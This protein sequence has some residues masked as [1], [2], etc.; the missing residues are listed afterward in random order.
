MSSRQQHGCTCSA[1]LIVPFGRTVDTAGNLFIADIHNYRLRRVDAA[2]GIVTTV[3][4]AGT[5]G[6]NGDG[7]AT[8]SAQRIGSSSA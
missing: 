6:Y 4:G 1:P 5:R 3:V 8:T 7:S 2:T